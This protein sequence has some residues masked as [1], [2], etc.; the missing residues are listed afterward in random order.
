MR[1]PHDTRTAPAAPPPNWSLT[2]P[3]WARSPAQARA[4]RGARRG[5]SL[6]AAA[7]LLRVRRPRGVTGA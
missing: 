6:A 4:G 1:P 2:L 5:L 7:R 3:A